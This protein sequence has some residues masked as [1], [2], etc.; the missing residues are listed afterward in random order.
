[1]KD[2][3]QGRAGQGTMDHDPSA[4]SLNIN[5]KASVRSTYRYILTRPPRRLRFRFNDASTWREA[6]P[7]ARPLCPA[8]LSTHR[9]KTSPLPL[10]T[11][12]SIS[13]KPPQPTSARPRS[14]QAG[15]IAQSNTG[16]PTSRI[17]IRQ[18]MF[19]DKSQETKQHTV[20]PA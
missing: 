18:L 14:S 2:T 12:T 16:S 9:Q 19:P 20:H 5:V 10:Q 3:G 17:R 6:P 11:D 15:A 1:M 8:A 13:L 7:R 4:A